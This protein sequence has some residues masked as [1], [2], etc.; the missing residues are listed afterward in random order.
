MR[1]GICFV[2]PA[3]QVKLAAALAA[4][5]RGR[6]LVGLKSFFADRAPHNLRDQDSFFTELLLES[7]LLDCV[8]LALLLEDSD[9]SFFADSGLSFAAA[10]L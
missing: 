4:E 1:Q 6:R 2:E 7:L 9:F 5:G 8:S 10:D 3:P